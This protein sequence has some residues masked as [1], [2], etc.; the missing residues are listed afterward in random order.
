M[1]ANCGLNIEV[2]IT[3]VVLKTGFTVHAS[4]AVAV[5][6]DSLLCLWNGR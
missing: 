3:Q 1:V 6:V 2:N 5:F 4:A